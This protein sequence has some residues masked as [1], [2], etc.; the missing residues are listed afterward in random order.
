MSTLHLVP[1][2]PDLLKQGWYFSQVPDDSFFNHPILSYTICQ[3][4]PETWT[5]RKT[6]EG[7]T[8]WYSWF[9]SVERWTEAPLGWSASSRGRPE[10]TGCT[11]VARKRD[12]QHHG[13]IKHVLTYWH[14]NLF[15]A[16]KP[17]WK[18]HGPENWHNIIET[19]VICKVGS[20][21]AKH[22]VTFLRGNGATFS[23]THWIKANGIRH[24][25]KFWVFF[26]RSA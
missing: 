4:P 3:L 17:T 1:E 21:E 26:P 10:R 8:T 16:V 2:A 9:L 11:C 24:L 6:T 5:G 22:F 12:P 18:Y 25:L 20:R 14:L 15:M 19:N 7:H 23:F 13:N